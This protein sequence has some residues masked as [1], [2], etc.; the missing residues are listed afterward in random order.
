M[1]V[2]NEPPVMGKSEGR[3]QGLDL[4]NPL[5][6]GGVPDIS[7]LSETSGF[8]SNFRGCVSRFIIG[9]VVSELMRDARM[10]VSF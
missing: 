7:L 2:N 1:L 9:L 5:Y 8:Y 6:I 3:F 10:Q 4:I